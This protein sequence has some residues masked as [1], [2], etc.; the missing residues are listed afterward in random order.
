MVLTS[1]VLAVLLI[2]AASNS[3]SAGRVPPDIIEASVCD[4]AQRPLEFAN[5]HVRTRGTVQ[6]GPEYFGLSDDACPSGD[7]VGGGIWLDLPGQDDISKY[8]RGWSTQRFIQATKSGELHGDGPAVSWQTP[9]SLAPLDPTQRE[10]LSRA[11]AG[12][13]HR[14]VNVI[15]TGRKQG[16]SVYYSVV[17]PVIFDLLDAAR[18]IFNNHLVDLQAAASVADD[19]TV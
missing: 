2:G 7:G 19:V 3:S 4:L 5:K 18:R 8:Y 15:V 10:R 12:S 16:T 11:L 14:A 17:D 13:Q 1:I 6:E 9:I